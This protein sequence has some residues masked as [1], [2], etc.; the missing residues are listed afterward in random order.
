MVLSQNQ[1]SNKIIARMLE[2]FVDVPNVGMVGA[3]RHPYSGQVQFF[4][5]NG[6]QLS[7]DRVKLAIFAMA[8]MEYNFKLVAA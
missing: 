8:I 7:T 2:G 4:D 5:I 1:E 6:A 3:Q